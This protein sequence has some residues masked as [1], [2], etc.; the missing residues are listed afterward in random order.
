MKKR[1][2]AVPAVLAVIVIII[3]VWRYGPGDS[4]ILR[5]EAEGTIYSQTAEAPGKIIEMTAGLG[6][7]V[8]SGEV[9]A[10]LD[11]TDQR[12]ALE[13]LE[14]TLE[15]A[16]LALKIL[17]GGAK[18]EELQNARSDID[19]AEANYRS[20]EAAYNQAR[21]DVEPLNHLL[22]IGGIARNELDNAKLRQ[23]MAAEAL[24]AAA[25][26][27]QK[28]K[29]QLSLLSKGADSDTIAMA[30]ADIAEIESRIRQSKEMLD[31]YEIKS[32]RAGIIISLNYNAGSM[33]N[34]GYNIADISADGENYVVFYLPREY[35][36]QI[37]YGQFLTVRSGKNE[38]SAEVRYIDVKNQ[39]TP[40]EMQTY[41]VKN[42]VSVKVKLLLPADAP[43][44]AGDSVDV[45]IKK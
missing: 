22:D 25:G 18:Q 3:L 20:A 41:A 42:K 14:I 43:I 10:R 39:Y 28:A 45:I 21:D 40:K 12:Y 11:D 13:Q 33:V 27:V 17:L 44:K 16:Q 23:T 29:E 1:I 4:I 9:I 35:S 31:K 37:T 36:P 30:E 34:P 38:Y 7:R 2:I 5:G 6:S 26:Q 24:Q 19:M 8:E 15:K 32:N